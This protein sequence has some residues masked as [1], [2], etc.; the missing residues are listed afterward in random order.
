M[1]FRAVIWKIFGAFFRKIVKPIMFMVPPDKTHQDAI[2][3]A[4]LIGNCRFMRWLTRTVFKVKNDA[5]LA[6]KLNGLDFKNPV[7]LSA[8]FDKNG[9]VVEAMSNLGFGFGEV[10]SITAEMCAGNPKPWFYRLP[11]TK[12]LV[13]NAGLANDGSKVILTRVNNN[14]KKVFTEYVPFLS[15]AKANDKN[16]VS[17]QEGIED[18]MKTL[19]RVKGNKNI[20]ALEL[21]ISCPNVFGGEPFTDPVSLKKLLKVVASLK[22]DKPIFIKMPSN[23]EWSEAKKLTD[24]IVD[25][26]LAGV[27][28]ANLSKTREAV[29]PGDD[30]PTEIEGSLSGMPTRDKNDDLVRSIFLEYG[31]ELTIIGVGGIFSVDDAYKKIRLGASLVEFI[32]GMIFIGPQLASEINYGLIKKLKKDGFDNISQAIGVDAKR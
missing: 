23:L 2:K 11:K 32:T 30:L 24:V 12:S 5:V 9:E 31:S 14:A 27:T 18:Y 17:V 22:I 15:I 20:G 4:T 1:K 7:G 16:C 26:K 21:N 6:Q 25:F 10:G 29:D 3:I 8:G 28:V 19:K 13:V